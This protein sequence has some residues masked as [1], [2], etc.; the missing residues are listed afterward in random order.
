MRISD[1]NRRFESGGRVLFGL[2]DF[3]EIAFTLPVISDSVVRQLE[4]GTARGSNTDLVLDI[5]VSGLGYVLVGGRTHG[6]L[7]RSA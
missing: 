7:E 4:G 2:R 3:S 6:L 1:V 5:A